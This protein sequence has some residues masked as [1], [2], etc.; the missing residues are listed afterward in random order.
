MAAHHGDLI[1]LVKKLTLAYWW[2]EIICR[3]SFEA[4]DP[5]GPSA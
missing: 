3:R 4:V 5:I 2:R 1:G